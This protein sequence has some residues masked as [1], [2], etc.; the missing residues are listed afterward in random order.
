MAKKAVKKTAVAAIAKPKVDYATDKDIQVL[1]QVYL[2][3][4]ARIDRLVAALSTAKPIK[5]D[6]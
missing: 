5:K 3:I 2:T 6:M 1:H 4:T